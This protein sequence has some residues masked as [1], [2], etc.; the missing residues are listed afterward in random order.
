MERT[1]GEPD[2]IVHDKQAGEF[3][4]FDCQRKVLKAAAEVHRSGTVPIPLT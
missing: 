1:G 4:F 2:V 3:I